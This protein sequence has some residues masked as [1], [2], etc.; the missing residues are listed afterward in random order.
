M[1]PLSFSVS[2]T[3]TPSFSETLSLVRTVAMC[4][5][6]LTNHGRTI[7][8]VGSTPDRASF[9]DT[10]QW[11]VKLQASFFDQTIAGILFLDD[12]ASG[13]TG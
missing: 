8:N 13:Y 11:D 2:V 10:V 1:V 6:C 7:S 3:V 9:T 5:L 12:A 4:I